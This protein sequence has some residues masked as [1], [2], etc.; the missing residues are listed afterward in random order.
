VMDVTGSGPKYRPSR[1]VSLGS[2]P[3]A[4]LI[5]YVGGTLTMVPIVM[6]MR[7]PW[8]S[9]AGVTKCSWPSL[10]TGVF[11][12]I[13]VALAILL[14]PKLGAATVVALIV[15]GQLL[16]SLTFDH[17]GMFGVPQRPAD[18]Y[19]LVGAAMPLGGVVLIRS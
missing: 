18:V 9:M 6:R 12:V 7:E 16:A 1:Q 4:A 17:F 2:A 13:Y 10:A 11:G 15:A 5:G 8:I 14:I 3:W 19:R